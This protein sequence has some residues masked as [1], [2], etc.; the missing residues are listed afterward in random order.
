M[1]VKRIFV[2][3]ESN[4]ERKCKKLNETGNRA[5]VKVKETGWISLR[6]RGIK[7]EQIVGK[8]GE[9]GARVIHRI[10]LVPCLV[11]LSNSPPSL[12]GVKRSH[13]SN[14]V[15]AL[16]ATPARRDKWGTSNL[17]RIRSRDIAVWPE[18]CLPA[19]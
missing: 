2:T 7:N 13:A 18:P 17:Y 16:H 6:N 12:G 5:E 9:D 8:R 14:D 10:G 19:N 4:R 15:L 1:A 3:I 11:R